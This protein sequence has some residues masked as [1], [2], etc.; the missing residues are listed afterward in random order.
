MSRLLSTTARIGST[1]LDSQ[2]T[3]LVESYANKLFALFGPLL[4]TD[5]LDS[6]GW[7]NF[8]RAFS[9]VLS[10]AAPKQRRNELPG[11][12]NRFARDH[13]SQSRCARLLGCLGG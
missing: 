1:S 5:F 8:S 13:A 4:D 11:G 12:R 10:F 2:L 9:V 3:E 7:I 6:I